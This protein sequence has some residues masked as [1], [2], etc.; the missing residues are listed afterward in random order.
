MLI[1]SMSPI[2]SAVV[3]GALGVVIV[4]GLAAYGVKIGLKH[5]S[6]NALEWF[7]MTINYYVDPRHW[8]WKQS[9]RR[10]CNQWEAFSHFFCWAA[11]QSI[12]E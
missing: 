12:R 3:G 2:R 4:L 11:F 5:G 1:R 7:L 10:C 8:C 9:R 6:G